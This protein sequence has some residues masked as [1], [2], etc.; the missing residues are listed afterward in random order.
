MRVAIWLAV[1][2]LAVCSPLFADD[3]PLLAE[4]P[5]DP[6][7]IVRAARRVEPD[8]KGDSQRLAQYLDGFRRELADDRRLVACD[9]TPEAV[10]AS[11]VRLT[12]WV[13]LP[14]T[15][16][17]LAAFYAALGFSGVDNQIETLPAPD[18]GEERFGFVNVPHSLS[19]EEPRKRATVG[20]DCML[21]EPL[22]L[23]REV[24][25][26]YLAHAGDG[27]LGYIPTADVHRVAEKEFAAYQDGTIAQLRSDHKT[28]DGANLPAGARLKWIRND[29]DN[30][31]VRL[32]GGTEASL[33]AAVCDVRKAPQASIEQ[34]LAGADQLKGT[35]YFWG[36]KTS[37]GVDCSGLVQVAFAGVGV[38]MPRDANQQFHVGRLTGT[39]WCM[40]TMRRGD[41]L[42]FVGAEGRVRH[43]G[44]YLGDGKYIHAGSP[45]VMINSLIPGEENYDERRHAAFAFARRVWE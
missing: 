5:I 14:E 45:T 20:T 26:F 23:L 9:V 42:Y 6:A 29:G 34:M 2:A 31:V 11:G 36:G 18:L 19:L 1:G 4:R 32:P 39:R 15:R 44:L 25:G 40:A 24:D 38:R 3:H 7:V 12:G 16:N 27:Y 33:P 10:G 30:V 13:E 35:Q 43:T 17:A 41:T 37:G 22:L 21:G 8:L 28:A